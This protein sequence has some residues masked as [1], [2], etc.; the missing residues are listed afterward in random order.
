MWDVHYDRLS[1]NLMAILGDDVIDMGPMPKDDEELIT[2]IYS[3]RTGKRKFPSFVRQPML[4]SSVSSH[5]GFV[6]LMLDRCGCRWPRNSSP[7][8]LLHDGSSRWPERYGDNGCIR[9]VSGIC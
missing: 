7:S 1:I 5:L 4:P 2:Q 9:S 3:K 6:I 8:C